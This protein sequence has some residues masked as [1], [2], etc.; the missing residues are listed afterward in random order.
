MKLRPIYL[1]LAAINFLVLVAIVLFFS[2]VSFIRGFLGDT[3]IVPFLYLLV[4]GFFTLEKK[5][6]FISV[7]GFSYIIEILQGFQLV[8]LLRLEEYKLAKIILGSTF[9]PMDFLAYTIGGLTIFFAD[10]DQ[11]K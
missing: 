10:R 5:I 3:L 8:T 6:V 11:K 1:F 7:L 4:R 2:K 9:D